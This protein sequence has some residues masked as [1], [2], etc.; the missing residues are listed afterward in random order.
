MNVNTNRIKIGDC[1]RVRHVDESKI[2]NVKTKS[3]ITKAP[4]KEDELLKNIAR[5]SFRVCLIAPGGPHDQHRAVFLTG[6]NVRKQEV[7]TL[8]TYLNNVIE[9]VDGIED[10]ECEVENEHEEN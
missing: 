10:D 2:W 6:S 1:V 3:Y 4:D 7:I 5:I 9:C 8:E